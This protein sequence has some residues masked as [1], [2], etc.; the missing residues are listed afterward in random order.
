MLPLYFPLAAFAGWK[1]LVEMGASPFYWDKTAHGL[2][3]SA[4]QPALVQG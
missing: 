4:P 2:H 3:D 1:A